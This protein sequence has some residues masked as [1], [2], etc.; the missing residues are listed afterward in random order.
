MLWVMD[1]RE[2]HRAQLRLPARLRWTSPFGQKTEVCKTLNVSRG[3][4]LVPCEESHAPGVPLWVTFP[5]DSSLPD[6][7]PELLARV[8]RSV[9]PSGTPSGPALPDI[10]AFQQPA[11]A[12]QFEAAPRPASN[13]NGHL[14]TLERRASPRRRVALPIHVRARDIPWFEEAMTV[15]VSSEG[16]LFLSSREYEPGQQLFLSFGASAFVP[17]SSAGE[18]RSTVVRVEPVP[19]SSALAITIRRVA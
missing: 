18:F 16:M 4:M 5:Y 13:G 12:L 3:G 10:D 8:V 2:H 15:N 1:R 17:W 9:G 7:Q 11:A 14:R 6:G 19:R